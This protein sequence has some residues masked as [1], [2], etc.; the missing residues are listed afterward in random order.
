MRVIADPRRRNYAICLAEDDTYIGNIYLVNIEGG[1]GDLGIFIGDRQHH[2]KGY[3]YQ[4]LVLL[5]E[6][7]RLELGIQ[8]INIEVDVDNVPALVSYL[9]SGARF[10]APYRENQVKL[11]LIV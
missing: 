5:K 3:A 6:L 1:C 2:G 10:P 11:E 9:K 4:A 8:R 7:A